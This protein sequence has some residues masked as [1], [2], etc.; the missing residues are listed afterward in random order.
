[1]PEV[2][3]DDITKVSRDMAAYLLRRL[4]EDDRVRMLASYVATIEELLDRYRDV[5]AI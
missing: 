2:N 3:E 4:R 5:P 1:M